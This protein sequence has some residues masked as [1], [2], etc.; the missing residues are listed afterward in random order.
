M[1]STRP[2]YYGECAGGDAGLFTTPGYPPP[3][4]PGVC[5]FGRF[6]GP[7]GGGTAPRENARC[8]RCAFFNALTWWLI[9]PF[10]T[11]NP[12]S[13]TTSAVEHLPHF[14]G[15]PPW[16]PEEPKALLSQVLKPGRP[17]SP[18]PPSWQSFTKALR[19]PKNN[20]ASMDHVAPELYWCLPRELHWDLY[21]VVRHVWESGDVPYQWLQARIAMIYKSG[22]PQA[23]RSCR[24]IS[25]ATGI[26]SILARLIL[27]TLRGPIDAALSDPHAGCSRGYTTSQQAL[28]MSMLLHQYG[29]GALV[30]LV[31]IAKAY[32]SMPHE[33]LTYGL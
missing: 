31:D 5:T 24:P 3:L 25:V 8:I 32:P 16:R 22:P 28:R 20:G 2:L 11:T 1:R 18:D 14:A 33:C 9:T 13:D 27:D 30:C 4:L 12:Q 26:Y 21:I 29:D 17:I 19:Q 7:S 10:R 15:D 6:C 23:A